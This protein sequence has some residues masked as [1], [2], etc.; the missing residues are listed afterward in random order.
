[1]AIFLKAIASHTYEDV[2]YKLTV[3]ENGNVRCSCPAYR[4]GK[5]KPCK[6]IKQWASRPEWQ[7]ELDAATLQAMAE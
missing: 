5:G 7:D 2:T 3:T 6:H 4:F 1:M